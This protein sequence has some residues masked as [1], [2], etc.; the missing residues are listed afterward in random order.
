MHDLPKLD[1]QQ[2]QFASIAKKDD[3]NHRLDDKNP[4][5]ISGLWRVVVT[6]VAQVPRQTPI[7]S[8]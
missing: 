1:A 4:P 6:L 8:P 3:Q 7:T 2:T 5:I